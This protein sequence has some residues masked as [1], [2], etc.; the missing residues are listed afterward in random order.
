M[1]QISPSKFP[2]KGS[3][4][5]II[6]SVD[7]SR[8]IPS[9]TIAGIVWSVSGTGAPTFS[10]EVV[11]GKKATVKIAGGTAG[12]TYTVVCQMTTTT[13]GEIFQARVPLTIL[14]AA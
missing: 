13:S 11:S 10:S 4:E 7:W 2:D 12:S 1:T 9:D 3:G 6:H 5:T 14:A 8:V